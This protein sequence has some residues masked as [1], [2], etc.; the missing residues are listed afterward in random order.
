M[1]IL[2]CLAIALLAGLLSGCTTEYRDGETTVFTFAW[3]IPTL[4]ILGGIVALLVGLVIVR[5]GGKWGWALI[6]LGP[7][8]AVVLG[9][10]LVQ[11]KV[12]I[13][14]SGFTLRTGFWFAPTLY[15]VRFKDVTGMQLIS[16]S[17]RR[18][19]KSY[20]ILCLTRSGSQKVPEGDLMRN[21]PSDRILE[22]AA[23]LG[24]PIED[25]TGK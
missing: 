18:G 23:E 9:P 6:I 16:E 1:V 24:I 19:R 14:Q 15:E 11:D 13:N 7:L 17:G 12:T 10:G 3:Y 8:A 22:M 4:V 21:G 5:K 2:R 20:Y 25:R